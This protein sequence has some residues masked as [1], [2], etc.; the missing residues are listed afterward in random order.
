MANVYI[1]L[2]S[3]LENP[4]SQLQ[5]AVQ[6]LQALPATV[7]VGCS[8]FYGSKPLGP[9]DQPD[10]V[11]AVCQLETQLTPQALLSA[12]QQIEIDQGRIKKRHWGER[13][14]DLDI[15]LYADQIIKTAE[16]TVPH[17][18]IALRD[19]VLIPLAEIAPGLVIPHLGRVE[20]LISNLETSYLKPLT[21]SL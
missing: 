16:L 8:Q 5:I 21:L 1:G 17:S 6:Y 7:L 4:L 10:F 12:L 9:D 18:E 20:T 15:L 13:L 11:N 19:F 3:N 14:I 2:G